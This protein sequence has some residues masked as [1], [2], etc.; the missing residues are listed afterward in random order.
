MINPSSE[1]PPIPK[2]PK[3]I[4]DASNLVFE[5]EEMIQSQMPSHLPLQFL[6]STIVKY[7][8][9][10]IA[11]LELRKTNETIKNMSREI[12]EALEIMG[13][14]LI[15]APDLVDFIKD[16]LPKTF[17]MRDDEA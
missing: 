7:Q 5:I 11:V 14:P 3:D 17:G 10:R 12:K 13:Q 1:I 16:N 4:P 15:T 6:L 9:M 8:Q 2:F